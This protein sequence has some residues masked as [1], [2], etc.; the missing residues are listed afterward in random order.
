MGYLGI[1][2]V[3]EPQ[4]RSVSPGDP[5][6]QAGILEGDVIAALEGKAV[7]Q[8]ELIETI[9]ASA[10][11]SLQLTV[12]RGDEHKDLDVTPALVGDVGLIGV[13]ISPYVVRIIE[14]GFVEAFGLSL[15]QNYEWTG[16]IMET[17]A[18][19]F[20]ADTSPSQLVGPVGI[21]QLSGSAAEISWVAL[22]SLMSMISLNLGLL[23]LLPVPVLDGGHITIMA[24]EGLSRRDFS[25]RAKERMLLVGLVLLLTL[26][27]TVIYN[28]LTRIAWIERLMPWR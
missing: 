19:L 25:T 9:N 16:L 5:A 24:L 1:G 15:E 8:E 3:M 26:M 10:G 11:T 13:S 6:D 23:N 21:A 4:I 7:S 17:L 14:P 12:R 20:T 18:G 28:D 2:P 22:F 27:V